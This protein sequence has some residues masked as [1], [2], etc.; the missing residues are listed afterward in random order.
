[1]STKDTGGSKATGVS[2]RDFLRLAGAGAGAGFIIAACRPNAR[3]FL[4][5]SPHEIPEDT[6]SGLENW[7]ASSHGENGVIVRVIEGRAKKVEGNPIHPVNGDP[8]A[9]LYK[10][11]GKLNAKGQALV[12][13]L[14][15]PDRIRR[16]LVQEPRGSGS[17]RE[18]EWDEALD[19]LYAFLN[20]AREEGRSGDVVLVSDPIG[21]VGGGIASRFMSAYGGQYLT[22]QALDDINLRRALSDLLG[23]DTL[24]EFDIANTRY[25][26]TFG[27]D[28]LNGWIAQVRHSKH[29]GE[30]RQGGEKR[31]RMVAIESRFSLTAANADDW[32]PLKPGGEGKLALSMA[33]VL[34]ESGL[35][36]EGAAA[37]LFGEDPAEALRP[38]APEAVAGDIGVT[39]ER[40]RELAEDFGDPGHGPALAI[41]G[42]SAG[43]HT[44]GVANLR[45]IYALNFLVGSVGEPGGVILNPSPPVG[46]DSLFGDGAGLVA[47]PSASHED[48]RRLTGRMASGN[49]RL[50][51]VRNAD[52][53]H[54]LP[55]Q[56]GFE[57]ALDRVQDIVSFSSFLDD[58]SLHAD[59]ILPSHVALEDWGAWSP[60]PGPGHQVVNVSQPVVN[61][62]NDTRGFADVLLAAAQDLGL[63]G[64]LPWES[65][66]AALQEVADLLRNAG[67]GNVE[68]A[69]PE[70]YWVDLLRQ[71]GWWDADRRAPAAPRPP[72][73]ELKADAS[74]AGSSSE[75]PYYLV[76]FE[77]LGIG[78]GRGAHLP[79]LQ[80]LPDPISTA[81]WVTW[82]EMNRQ[83]ALARGVKEGAVYRLESPGGVIE[84]AVYLN[85]ATPPDVLAVPMGQGRRALGRWAE[86]RGSNPFDALVGQV[87]VDTGA[88]AW[89]GTRV[90]LVDT[91]RRV[92]I[93]KME[94]AV[95]V[96]DYG[97]LSAEDPFDRDSEVRIDREGFII[98]VTGE[99]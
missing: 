50:L 18:I 34:V 83:E 40:I 97:R 65:S 6:V 62:F 98:K 35:A 77:Q 44:N 58:T 33:Q 95:F 39:A 38:Y 96:V 4:E 8:S 30:F 25:L 5:Q 63:E 67:G 93:P 11:T 36:D 42:G 99:K 68:G 19:R 72:R 7:Y 84:A 71:G 24:P 76:P 69:S 79:W 92:R 15:H 55:G 86:G 9:D 88:L 13:E 22:Y 60:N 14:Y 91:G 73:I 10:P 94:G 75:Y 27:A 64:E 57:T 12:Q 31:G 49:V 41:G 51:M 85:P 74:I 2:R 45:A 90:R 81:T 70:A 53:I 21:G 26:Y 54:G 56:L 3:E 47:A 87:D 20:A 78:D 80:S 46:L 29:Y 23:G 1:M 52:L 17:F 32:V 66:Y 61:P 48:M 59:L 82:V 28:F 16:P 89:A 43:A 37:A